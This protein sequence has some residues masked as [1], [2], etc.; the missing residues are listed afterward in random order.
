VLSVGQNELCVD[1]TRFGQERLS[2]PG[3]LSEFEKV[4]NLLEFTEEPEATQFRQSKKFWP[5]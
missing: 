2:K 1:Y 3:D 5:E 4:G